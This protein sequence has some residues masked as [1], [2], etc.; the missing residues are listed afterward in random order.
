MENKKAMSKWILLAIILILIIL[1]YVL[2]A[3]QYNFDFGG[4]LEKISSFIQRS[5]LPTPPALPD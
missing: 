5:K 2:L 3:L 4:V 1:M